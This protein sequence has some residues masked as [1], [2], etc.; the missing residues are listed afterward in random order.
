VARAPA[1]PAGA[2]A[3]ARQHARP[4]LHRRRLFVAALALNTGW[5][6]AHRVLYE[7]GGQRPTA[8]IAVRAAM[9]DAGLI[10]AAAE[11]AGP[12][13]RRSGA[14]FWGPLVGGLGVIAVAIEA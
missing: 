2:R 12:L 1:V 9:V 3:A 13:R 6:L 10:L 7:H 14:L 5:E 8:L 4:S 11:A